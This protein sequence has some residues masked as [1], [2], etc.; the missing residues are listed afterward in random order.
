VPVILI[1][2]LCVTVLPAPAYADGGDL[3]CGGGSVA[4]GSLFNTA[5]FCQNEGSFIEHLF[6]NI[7]CMY[8]RIIDAILDRLY[9]SIQ[10][11]V[12]PVLA[13]V[14]ILYIAV[15]GVQIL[16]GMAQLNG[17]EIVV[18]LAKI[19][20]VWAFATNASY[21]IGIGFN[22]FMAVM[23]DGVKWVINAI[24]VGGNDP[25]GAY[26]Y[27]D[28]LIY[29]AIIGPFTESNY[30][31]VGFFLVMA[32]VFFPITLMG[33][34][35]MIETLLLLIS[36]VLIF[37]LSISAVAFLIALSPI[38]LSFMLFQSTFYLFENWLRYMISYSLQVIVVFAI[39]CMWVMVIQ[40]FVGFFNNLA[41][42][43]VPYKDV[44]QPANTYQTTN[45]WGICKPTFSMNSFGP[46]ATCGAGKTIP[47]SGIMEIK[48]FIYY[49]TFHMITLILI[50]YSFRILLKNANQIAKDLVGPAYVPM[51]GADFGMKALG[52][53][54][55]YPNSRHDMRSM[56][57][58]GG[59]KPGGGGGGGKK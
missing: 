41:D 17:S 43:I 46:T 26:Q 24:G 36:C 53:P 3:S 7:I 40:Q 42:M 57:G 48:G 23:N 47:P 34:S 29:Q 6:S 1:L 39:V 35:F 38:F 12:Q 8:V 32:L 28:N 13:T 5:N 16:T 37:L 2:A 44:V 15:F 31:V 19:A 27:I 52:D 22:F 50:A 55:A 4:G 11:T 14:I 49:I 59:G 58:G 33:L 20:F 9:C 25:M 51:L 30:K 10:Q 45:T 21:G 56:A 54:G 18:R